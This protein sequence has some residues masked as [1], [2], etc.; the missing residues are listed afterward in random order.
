MKL[1]N[2]GRAL[3]AAAALL[4]FPALT[5]SVAD[6]AADPAERSGARFTAT[7]V[8]R[9]SD[10]CLDVEGV[11]TQQGANVHQWTC[12]NGQPNQQWH[13]VATSG[14]YYTIRAAHS[15]K[16]L[17]VWGVSTAD[18]AN[19]HQWTCLPNQRNQEWK[20]VQ[21]DNGYFT[22]VARHSGKCLDV[23]GVSA[24]DGANVHQWTCLPRQRNQEWRLG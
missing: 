12:I 21:K 17:D 20:L 16:C 15:G 18:G 7:L 8:A 11:S 19:V 23:S 6:A 22:V 13:L 2:A 4:A 24:A 9:H 3:A 5:V 10:K 14:G 1:V